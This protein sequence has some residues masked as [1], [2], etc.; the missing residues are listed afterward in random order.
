MIY[1][2]D[3]SGLYYS[4]SEHFHRQRFFSKELSLF[5][6][7]VSQQSKMRRKTDSVYICQ[8][9]RIEYMHPNFNRKKNH[10]LH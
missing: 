5:K 2:I 1:I 6:I 4:L 8:Q 3:H 10:N 7:N 9:A